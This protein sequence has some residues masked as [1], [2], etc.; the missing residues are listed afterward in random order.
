MCPGSVP[1][2]GANPG[3]RRHSSSCPRVLLW[4]LLPDDNVAPIAGCLDFSFVLY[5]GSH[6]LRDAAPGPVILCHYAAFYCHFFLVL[7]PPVFIA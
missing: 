5:P 6:T 1:Q 2:G 3:R 7:H 4:T